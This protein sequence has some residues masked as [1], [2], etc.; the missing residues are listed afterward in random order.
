[1]LAAGM[2]WPHGLQPTTGAVHGLYGLAHQNPNA[3]DQPDMLMQGASLI[4]KATLHAATFGGVA[5]ATC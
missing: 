5:T 2:Q 3:L 1:M 4:L